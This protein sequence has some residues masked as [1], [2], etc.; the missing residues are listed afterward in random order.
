VVRVTA[1]VA[2]AQFAT[3]KVLTEFLRRYL[4]I[5]IAQH[6][7]DASVDLVAENFDLAI[8]AHSNGLPDSN[9][10]ARTL[11]EAPWRLFTSSGYVKVHGLPASPSALSVRGALLM[12]RYGSQPS[13]QLEHPNGEEHQIAFSPRFMT[14]DLVGLM[15]TAQ[16][17]LGI[18][19]LPAYICHENLARGTMCAVLAEWSGGESTLTALVT[20]RRGMLPSA[21]VLMDYLLEELPK[22]LSA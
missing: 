16:E 2:T 3:S 6:V 14:D 5:N 10:V 11:G 18:V 22:D 15:A 8:R 19:A 21:R 1:A 20:N 12:L 4:L 7:T 17:G 13:W 9:F